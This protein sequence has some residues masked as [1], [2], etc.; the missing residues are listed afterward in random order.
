MRMDGGKKKCRQHSLQAQ[1]VVPIVCAEAGG[2]GGRGGGLT[3]TFS[4]SHKT[5]DA[6]TGLSWFQSTLPSSAECLRRLASVADTE[7]IDEGYLGIRVRTVRNR[8]N[9]GEASAEQR[10]KAWTETEADPTRMLSETRSLPQ[11]AMCRFGLPRFSMMKQ[12]NTSTKASTSSTAAVQK[13]S[14]LP[15]SADIH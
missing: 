4:A 12:H 3:G 6:K 8:C 15:Q 5:D 9:R 2:G 13:S 7:E 11:G 14:T 10:D 1:Q